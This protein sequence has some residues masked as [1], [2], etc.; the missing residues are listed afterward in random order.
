MDR[1]TIKI[2]TTADVRNR[3]KVEAAQ[4]GWSMND[5][6]IDAACAHL[7][8]TL[9]TAPPGAPFT[10]NPLIR[11]VRDFVNSACETGEEYRVPSKDLYRCFRA[12]SDAARRVCPADGMFGAAM[13]AAFPHLP[14]ARV[15]IDGRLTYVYRGIRL[16]PDSQGMAKPDSQGM[17]K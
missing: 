12:S 7:G 9:S 11:A 8:I 1:V 15:R 13:S 10:E 3:L 4:R 5:L 16:R 17:A 6:I 2:N 14:K